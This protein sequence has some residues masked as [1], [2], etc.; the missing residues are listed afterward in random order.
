MAH[1]KLETYGISDIGL[2]RPTNEDVWAFHEESGFFVLADGMGG[3]AAGEVAAKLAVDELCTKARP[4][5]FFTTPEDLALFIHEAILDTN[6]HIYR[7][8]LQDSS[9]WGMGT[10]LCCMQIYEK[11]LIYA[12]VGDSRL[13][14]LRD[15]SLQQL[16]KDHTLCK[17]HNNST[18]FLLTRALGASSYVRPSIASTSIKESDIYFLCSDGLTDYV[19]DKEISYILSKNQNVKNSSEELISLAKSKGGGDNITILMV[20][21]KKN[22]L[23]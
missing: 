7:K 3:H 9:L 19:Q 13:Y 16:T 10:T 17:S 22:D 2:R 20:K 12:H 15:H 21:I 1:I 23:L 8:A 6:Q 5:S 14:R 11:T 4:P 18:R